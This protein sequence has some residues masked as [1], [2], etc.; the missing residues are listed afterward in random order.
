MFCWYKL[1]SI[2]NLKKQKLKVLFG[3]AGFKVSSGSS[4]SRGAF[5]AGSVVPYDD[6]DALA[7]RAFPTCESVGDGGGGVALLCKD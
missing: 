4:I 7:R 1:Q 5:G 2:A 3:I 6:E